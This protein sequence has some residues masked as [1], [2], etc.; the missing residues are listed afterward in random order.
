MTTTTKQLKPHP[1]KGKKRGPITK[2]RKAELARLRD[3]AEKDRISQVRAGILKL[4]LV[5]VW[6]VRVDARGRV[7]ILKTKARSTLSVGGTL[8]YRHD[9]HR[10]V[11]NDSSGNR[12]P[13]SKYVYFRDCY[14]VKRVAEAMA[15]EKREAILCEAT[16]RL[17]RA[18]AVKVLAQAQMDER[19]P[20]IED[21]ELQASY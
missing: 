14:E 4:P 1:M 7:S 2:E 13:P 17:S 21:P 11:G 9:A 12:I 15:E 18:T 20:I 16:L 5:D 8:Y 6:V 19:T 10:L 3:Q